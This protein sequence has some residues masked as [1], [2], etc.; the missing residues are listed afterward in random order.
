MWAKALDFLEPFFKPAPP[1]TERPEANSEAGR[2]IR[3][4][5][6]VRLTI[7]GLAIWLPFALVFLDWWIFS[8]NPVPRDSMSVYYYSGMREVFTVTL[9]T[10]AFFL[11]TY[12]I[13]EKNLDNTLSVF[14]GLAGMLIPL[15]PTGRPG[16][17]VATTKLNPLQNLIGEDWTKWVHYGASAVFIGCLGGVAWLFGRREAVRGPHGARFSGAFWQ[18][19]HRACA[20]LVG[21]AGGWIIATTIKFG[22]GPLID[23]P[24]W[25][26]YAGE[27]TASLAFGASWFAKGFEIKYLFNRSPAEVVDT[28]EEEHFDLAT[29]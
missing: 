20:I 9:G 2:Y 15:F 10:M 12:K 25:S 16:A 11:F 23:G 28:P 21:V 13:T 6:V 19:Y 29:S 26:L 4:F 27:L 3:S 8:G 18:N 24:Y 7:G 1:A 22:S 14:A 17:L 5:L